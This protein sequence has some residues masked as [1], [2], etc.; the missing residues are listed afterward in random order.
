MTG[1]APNDNRASRR[2]RAKPGA[3]YL[4][5]SREGGATLPRYIAGLAV[6]LL[7]WVTGTLVVQVTALGGGSAATATRAGS[8]DRRGEVAAMST[9]LPE[10]VGTPPAPSSSWCPGGCKIV[11]VPDDAGTVAPACPGRSAA[12]D[13]Q[14]L[15][16]PS[17]LRLASAICHLDAALSRLNGC[18]DAG[19]DP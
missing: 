13:R 14:G 17:A 6:I 12:R 5:W 10:A 9:R 4:S 15:P 7:G 8:T 16:A 3:T 18:A 11:A 2:P 19:R 1:P